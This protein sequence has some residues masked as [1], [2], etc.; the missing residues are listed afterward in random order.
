MA[1]PGTYISAVGHAG[2]VAW[3]ILGWGLSSDPL[4]F[5]IAEVSVVSGEEYAALVAATTP[6]PG[7]ASPAAPV[8]PEVDDAPDA[9]APEVAPEVVEAPEPVE[10][11][12]EEAPPPEP[13]APPAPPTELSDTVPDV[14]PPAD[15]AS[16]EI[17][18]PDTSDPP[19]ARPVPRVAPQPVAP[20]EPEVDVADV[21]Q[22]TTTP[23]PATEPTPQEP[24]EET[25]P[26]ETV[27][28][29][30]TEAETP[31]AAPARSLRP[32]VRP[33]RPTPTET[34]EVT[35]PEPQAPSDDAAVTAALEA[36]L[37]SDAPAVPQ[38][39]PLTG[40]ERDGFRVAV[41]ACWNVDPGSEAAR[42][43]MTVAFNL[44]R[45]GRVDGAVRQVS[46]SGG[47]DAAQRTA[48]QSARRAI[49]RCQG[50]GGYDLPA[51]KYDQWRE[52]EITFDPTGMR[53][54]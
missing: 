21:V 16:P 7:D 9:P 14:A 5:E 50:Q 44:T 27:T 36:A 10:T 3:L 17:L 23:D 52:V 20:S 11:P 39:P 2:L 13:P 12:V 54:R 4:P 28:E 29:I 18:A 48:F 35:E 32:Q 15:E 41:N 47:S 6:D 53:L 31:S 19:Q 49:L 8:E 1:S 51:E 45:E 42:V 40:S 46:A 25:A 33:N 43:E 34:A 24:V 30:V 38:G 26:E 22:E 37:A